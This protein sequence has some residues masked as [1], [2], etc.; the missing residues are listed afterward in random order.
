MMETKRIMDPVNQ[1]LRTMRKLPSMS[2]VSRQAIALL[3]DRKSGASDVA[4]VI[5]RDEAMTA[6]ILRVVNSAFYGL[7]GRVKTV[8]HAVALLG[9]EQVRLLILGM[10]MFDSSEIRDPV[11]L[12]NRK[13]VWEHSQSCAQWSHAIAREMGF[14][15]PE[16]AFTAGLL[17]DIGKVVLSVSSPNEFASAV[18]LCE[19]E[20]VPS[21]ES[22][23]TLIGVDHVE[24]GLTLA[25]HW[26][27]PDVYSTCIAHHHDT[28]PP[29]QSK[30]AENGHTYRELLAIVRVANSAAWLL[31]SE[32]GDNNIGIENTP[33]TPL[34]PMVVRKMVE[35][36]DQFLNGLF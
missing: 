2:P 23:K 32:P 4:K 18:D 17:H 24:V 8:S 11:A 1:W 25:H 22:E 27:F 19:K 33:A 15:S 3:D 34:D 6:R 12:A 26:G 16:E 14:Q 20:G 30:V 9:F 31:R 21:S 35:K 29:T 13:L 5:N 36:A 10:V 7:S 28:W